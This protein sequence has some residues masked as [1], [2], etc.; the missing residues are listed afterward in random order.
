MIVPDPFVFVP[1]GARDIHADG[2]EARHLW[3]CVHVTRRPMVNATPRDLARRICQQCG[4]RWNQE[5]RP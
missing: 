4:N 5:G 1:E 2:T 3:S